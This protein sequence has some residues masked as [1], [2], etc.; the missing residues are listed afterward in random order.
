VTTLN[1]SSKAVFMSYASQDAEPVRRIADALQ[2]VGI[3]VWLDQSEL[4]GGEAWDASIRRQIKTCKLFL[5]VISAST[6]AR[7][8][9]YF[10]RDWNLAVARTLDMADDTAFLLPVVI[11]ATSDGE[12]RVPE[13]FRE[14][15]WTRLPGGATTAGFVERVR[16]L[17]LGSADPPTATPP[18]SPLPERGVPIVARGE[19]ST[20]PTQTRTRR[21]RRL[22]ILKLA[23]PAIL[24]IVA[25]ST[26]PTHRRCLG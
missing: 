15:Q 26:T 25:G 24:L 19:K 9:G 14:V 7:E 10:R 23:V 13:K 12:A 16:G 21:T 2:K 5:A 1:P 3:E 8:E 17:A 4:R 6:Q 22:T 20:A 11:D 18:R